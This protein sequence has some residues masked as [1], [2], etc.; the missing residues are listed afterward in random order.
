MKKIFILMVMFATM[1]MASCGGNG[2]KAD[3]DAADSTAVDS[4][5]VVDSVAADSVAVVD[6]IAVAE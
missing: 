1:C 3:G 4:V 2:Q 5:E 6:S